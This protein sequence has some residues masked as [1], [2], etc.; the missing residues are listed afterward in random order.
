[1]TYLYAL[2]HMG[3]DWLSPEMPQ[4][5]GSRRERTTRLA[6]PITD[7]NYLKTFV[8]SGGTT[9][10]ST[11]GR[12]SFNLTYGTNDFLLTTNI[13]FTVV[14][15]CSNYRT[16]GYTWCEIRI[17]RLITTKYSIYQYYLLLQ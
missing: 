10:R 12:L 14:I 2:V 5:R 7:H 3:S 9:G 17:K 16:R 15:A 1:M 8:F 6:L 11:Y 4:S 13:S